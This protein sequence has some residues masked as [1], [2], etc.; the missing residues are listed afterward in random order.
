M[1]HKGLIGPLLI[2]VYTSNPWEL[3][4]DWSDGFRLVIGPLRLKVQ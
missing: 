4:V 1:Y 2:E 3:I